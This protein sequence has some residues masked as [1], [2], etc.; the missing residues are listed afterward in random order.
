M[1][2]D[3]SQFGGQECTFHLQGQGW[4]SVFIEEAEQILFEDCD[5][6]DEGVGKVMI[7]SLGT[8]SEFGSSF[9]TNRIFTWKGSTG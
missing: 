9:P 3:L 4:N 8:V 6:N 2:S 7:R 5:I 1:G